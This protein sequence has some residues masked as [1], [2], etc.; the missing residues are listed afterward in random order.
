[1]KPAPASDTPRSTLND[2]K[3]DAARAHADEL[4]DR[5]L[6]ALEQVNWPAHPA[7]LIESAEASGAA[8]DVIEAL[9]ALPDE[10]YGSFP[11]VSASIVAARLRAHER[12]ERAEPARG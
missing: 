10:A 6:H 11:E 1:M 12:P 8:H 2:E 5:V 3:G 7:T 4:A 9:R